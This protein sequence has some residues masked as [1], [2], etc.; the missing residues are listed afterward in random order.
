MV[1]L[2][3]F[4]EFDGRKGGVLTWKRHTTIQLYCS[5]NPITVEKIHPFF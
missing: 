5:L 2:V 4:D 3:P 1:A